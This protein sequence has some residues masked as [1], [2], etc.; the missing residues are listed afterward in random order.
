MPGNGSIDQIQE[1][2]YSITNSINSPVLAKEKITIAVDSVESELYLPKST[3]STI[4]ELHRASMPSSSSSSLS[5]FADIQYFCKHFLLGL[6]TIVLASIACHTIYQFKIEHIQSYHEHLFSLADSPSDTSSLCR[7]VQLNFSLY[8]KI[9]GN[10]I[11]FSFLILLILLLIIVDNVSTRK[12]KSSWYDL[13]LPMIFH[14]HSHIYRF[15]SAAVFGLL[16]LEILHIFEEFIINGTEHF[17]RGPLIDLVIQFT[18][19]LLLGLR[20]FPILSIFEQEQTLNNRLGNI[21]CYACAT[22]YLY[23]EILF[24]FKS[25]MNCAIDKNKVTAMK[26]IIDRFNATGINIRDYVNLQMSK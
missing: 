8:Y 6:I 14:S 12:S 3:S 5:L 4:I 9:P 16:S 7:L 20:Y 15:E 18:I 24:K 19:T 23:C 26:D 11:S 17:H 25:E 21:L 10:Y 2:C 22:M 13:S 1:H